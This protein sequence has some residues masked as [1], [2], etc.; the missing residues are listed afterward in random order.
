[1]KSIKL[2]FKWNKK[3]LISDR[4]ALYESSAS[5]EVGWDN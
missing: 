2:D 3:T 5:D 1:M 4:N